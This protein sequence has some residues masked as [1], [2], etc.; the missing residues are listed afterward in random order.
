[1]TAVEISKMGWDRS[2]YVILARGDDFADALC[3]GPLARK[4]NAPILLT[5]P[6]CLNIDVLSEIKRLGANHVIIIGGRGAVSYNVE[7]YLMSQGIED[8]QRIFG[9][10]RYETS[11]KVAQALGPRH[12][13]AIATGAD[14]PDALSISPAAALTCMPIIL[15]KKDSLPHKVRQYIQNNEFDIVYIIG[16][17]G[18]ISPSALE[19]LPGQIRL[20]GSDRYETN[21]KV[22]EEFSDR[23][24]YSSVYI[25]IGEGL[26][27]DEFADAL[28]GASLA[29]KSSSPV[30]LVNNVLPHSTKV[31]LRQKLRQ[32]SKV[33]ALGGE[34]VVRQD[35]VD[36]IL[37]YI[38][39]N[40]S[41]TDNSSSSHEQSD[42]E[43]SEKLNLSWDDP[44]GEKK[45]GESVDVKFEVS[46]ANGQK[47]SGMYYYILQCQKDGISA[48]ED[49]ITVKYNDEVIP[50]L[51]GNY[52]IGTLH[53]VEGAESRRVNIAFKNSGLYTLTIYAAQ[54]M[55]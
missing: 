15:T 22:M 40:E 5:M 29:A 39:Q 6:G 28:A 14:Y 23:L 13:I 44:S 24:D 34:T 17:T 49:D 36:S 9:A 27:G 3:G 25:A 4:Y 12:I 46:T 21:I 2:E 26:Y 30:I 35:V 42:V 55:D 19:G 8:V 43:N 51:D 33:V 16:G 20:G 54:H 37:S 7:T 48:G 53:F 32:D 11:I 10:D 45:V 50:H 38:N 41:N 47:S 31:F 52:S 18:V 1:M